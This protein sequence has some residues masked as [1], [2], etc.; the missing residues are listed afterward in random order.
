MLFYKKTFW[1]LTI[2]LQ[3][4]ILFVT[5]CKEQIQP[6]PFSSIFELKLG[7]KNIY[8]EIAITDVQKAMG[9]MFRKSLPENNA[10]IFV[11][12]TPKQMSFWMKNTEIPLDIAFLTEDGVITEIKQMYP[13]N[14]NPVKS[15]RDDILYC[16]ETNAGWFA[17]NGIS[18]GKALDMQTF[19]K[20]LIARKAAE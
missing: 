10:M 6:K 9:L 20:A 5:S 17:K 4:L 16:I 19:K 1:T 7:D 18:A 15:S 3:A 14:L 8:A 11:F 13:S 2:F 12:N